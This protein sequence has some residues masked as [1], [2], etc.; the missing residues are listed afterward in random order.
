M[1]LLF[2]KIGIRGI[3][4]VLMF[5]VFLLK[6]LVV[7]C[8]FFI[9]FDSKFFRMEGFVLFWIIILDDCVVFFW[10]IME[11]FKNIKKNINLNFMFL[12][13]KYLKYRELDL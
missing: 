12:N 9:V 2:V 10:G 8:F 4:V 11:D 1:W 5:F 7:V 13:K 3:I 6:G